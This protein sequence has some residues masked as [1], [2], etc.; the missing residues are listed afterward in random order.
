MLYPCLASVFIPLSVSSPISNDWYSSMAAITGSIRTLIGPS[1]SGSLTDEAGI[2]FEDTSNGTIYK[3]NPQLH[4]EI[5]ELFIDKG[6]NIETRSYWDCTPLYV[7]ILVNRHDVAEL[8]L[9]IC[10]SISKLS[11]TSRSVK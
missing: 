2:K 3:S 11:W 1:N 5:I 9:E 7:A 6:A 8:L 4:N 10:L